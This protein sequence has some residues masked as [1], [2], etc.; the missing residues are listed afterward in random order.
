MG[1]IINR[2]MH[3]SLEGA[4]LHARQELEHHVDNVTVN[5]AKVHKRTGL[6]TLQEMGGSMHRDSAFAANISAI[7]AA[8]GPLTTFTTLPANGQIFNSRSI[9][10]CNR[11]H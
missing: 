2:H 9:A 6:L 8:A 5:L 3:S 4:L 10:I 7:A 11:N 1:G